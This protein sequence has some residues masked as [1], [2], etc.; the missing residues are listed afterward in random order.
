M[1]NKFENTDKPLNE[2]LKDGSEIVSV[3]QA[4]LKI[5]KDPDSDLAKRCESIWRTINDW[6]M[7]TDTAK[8]YSTARI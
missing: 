2:V 7:N 8:K 6:S 4:A 3:T 1:E 5:A